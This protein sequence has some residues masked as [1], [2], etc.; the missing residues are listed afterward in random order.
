[1]LHCFCTKCQRLGHE[2]ANCS[3]PTEVPTPDLLLLEYTENQTNESIT[4]K[5]TE[6]GQDDAIFGEMDTPLIAQGTTKTVS[7]IGFGLA[8]YEMASKAQLT[9]GR[10]SNDIGFTLGEQSSNVKTYGPLKQ[11]SSSSNVNKNKGLIIY[12]PSE[13]YQHY[14]S[15]PPTPQL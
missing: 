3:Y 6:T 12:P 15:S 14:S 7:A 13:T 11:G 5:G 4:G 1:M 10:P 8:D 9:E 2:I